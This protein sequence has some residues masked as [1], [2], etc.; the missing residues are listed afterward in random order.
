M[1][2]NN[3]AIVVKVKRTPSTC[4]FLIIGGPS[5]SYAL[6]IYAM[7]T[8][9]Q[10]KVK[11]FERLCPASHSENY[12]IERTMALPKSPPKAYP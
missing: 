3:Y 7:D 6:P 5:F 9:I 1:S 12:G 11:W 8:T 2:K 10:E 4:P